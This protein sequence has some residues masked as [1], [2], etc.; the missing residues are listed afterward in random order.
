[1]DNKYLMNIATI[2]FCIFYIFDFY[3]N[4][5]KQKY[6]LYEKIILL[7]GNTFAFSYSIKIN[8]ISLIFNYGCLFGLDIIL[9]IIIIYKKIIHNIENQKNIIH[10]I[11]NQ[12]NPIHHIENQTNTIHNCI[13]NQ[14]S[15]YSMCYV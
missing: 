2:L 7:S 1:M 15:E 13:K 9:I 14:Y 12:I 8:N 5:T 3:N 11:E 4:Y 10:H 6:N